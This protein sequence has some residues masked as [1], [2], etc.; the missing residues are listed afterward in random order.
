MD[1]I[2]KVL[3]KL[4]NSERNEFRKILVLIQKGDFDTLAIK[5]LKGQKNIYRVRKG[6]FRIIFQKKNDTINI[7]SL[8]KRSDNTY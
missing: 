1:K 5:K 2:E 7:L 4:L 6:K 3:K 8:E